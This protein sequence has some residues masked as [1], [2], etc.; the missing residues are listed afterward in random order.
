MNQRLDFLD[1]ARGIAALLVFFS[2]SLE[3]FVS[4][5]KK[6]GMNT[7]NFGQTG[8]VVFF[9]V[10]GFVI[11]YSMERNQRQLVFWISRAFRIYP[12]YIFV[13]TISVLL[14]FAGLNEGKTIFLNNISGNIIAHIFFIQSYLPVEAFGVTDFVDGSWTLFIE[15]FWYIFF[16]FLFFKGMQKKLLWVSGGINVI[17]VFLS[18][19]SI[20]SG[21]RIPFGIVCCFNLCIMGF[22][23]YQF[24]FN[25][26]SKQL[27][28]VLISF[29]LMVILIALF[30]GF[31]IHE[32][33]HFT[34]TCVITSWIS[35]LLIFN[36]FF[37]FHKRVFEFLAP[38]LKELGN[39]SYSLYLIHVC[40]LPTI[41]RFF[42]YGP[43]NVFIH[44][45]ISVGLSYLTFNFI[46]KPFIR[47]GKKLS[48]AVKKE[49]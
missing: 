32:N 47:A 34:G 12:L 30:T 41:S 3:H 25:K 18:I 21:K 11:P 17:I 1:Y 49:S 16:S 35:G 4:G 7:I 38:F 20:I 43:M 2:H 13:F 39:I 46:E 31:F 44:L 33:L 19:V 45:F 26:I 8:I 28:Q 15:F 5:W 24:Y 23:Y 27:F 10:S 14:A 22:V 9:L 36:F 6:I 29:S 40:I 37:L 48:G 42:D